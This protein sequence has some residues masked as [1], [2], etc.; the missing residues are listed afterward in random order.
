[1]RITCTC[2]VQRTF[3]TRDFAPDCRGA[4]KRGLTVAGK[5]EAE[6]A[7]ILSAVDY[8]Q[9]PTQPCVGERTTPYSPH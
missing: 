5:H 2:I 1:M 7:H 4:V 6:R 9:D 3:V 8:L